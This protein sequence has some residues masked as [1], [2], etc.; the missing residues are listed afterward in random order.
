MSNVTVRAYPSMNVTLDAAGLELV[1]EIAE[2]PDRTMITPTCPCQG[3][4]DGDTGGAVV[5]ANVRFFQ[6]KQVAAVLKH[7]VLVR[8]LGVNDA[9]R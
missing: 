2:E 5:S 6:T 1:K 4:F 7:G 8:Y 9:E 3:G